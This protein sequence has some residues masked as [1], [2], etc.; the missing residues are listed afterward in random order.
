MRLIELELMWTGTISRTDSGT[1]ARNRTR[2]RI[3][4][5]KRIKKEKKRRRNRENEIKKKRKIIIKGGEGVAPSWAVAFIRS[6]SGRLVPCFLWPLPRFE[7]ISCWI[8]R[9]YFI[10]IQLI[11]IEIDINLMNN[12]ND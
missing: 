10:L 6:K 11:I 2:N 1:D 7:L 8:T 5:R 12:I 9:L 3:E 4:K